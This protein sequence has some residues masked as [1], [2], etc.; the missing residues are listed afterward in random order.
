M[1]PS[2]HLPPQLEP[3]QVDPGVNHFRV[4]K[5]EVAENK[6]AT[7]G[8]LSTVP[9][10][11]SWATLG[12]LVT[13]KNKRLGG[14][15]GLPTYIPQPEPDREYWAL[16]LDVLLDS[17]GTR[18]L[19]NDQIWLR[20]IH[21]HPPGHG[22]T[23][24]GKWSSTS[25][26]YGDQDDFADYVD[27]VGGTNA[28]LHR[29]STALSRPTQQHSPTNPDGYHPNRQLS[30]TPSSTGTHSLYNVQ[31]NQWKSGTPHRGYEMHLLV[32]RSSRT[33][34]KIQWGWM[35]GCGCSTGT[36][37]CNRIFDGDPGTGTETFL[38]TYHYGAGS[39]GGR[40]WVQDIPA[41]A[42]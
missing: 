36:D 5:L 8:N 33:V 14:V 24:N 3:C 4:Y 40:W 35:L 42:Q 26:A 16:D 6:P 29:F 32:D 31:L 11:L 22:S 10:T 15:D 17:T 28:A 23:E 38:T 2:A 39:R 41:P 18:R 30:F 12:Y 19:F 9:T 37:D 7:T 21:K 1:A 34:E 13:V 25:A 20:T 27:F